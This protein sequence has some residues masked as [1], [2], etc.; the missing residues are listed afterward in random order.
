MTYKVPVGVSGSAPAAQLKRYAATGPRHISISVLLLLG[1]LIA[2][3]TSVAENNEMSPKPERKVADRPPIMEDVYVLIAEMQVTHRTERWAHEDKT[4]LEFEEFIE[5]AEA[6]R[7]PGLGV[8]LPK[9]EEC[10]EANG[11]KK[12]RTAYWPHNNTLEQPGDA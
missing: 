9:I 10:M 3:C 5:C 6:T 7:P 4:R 12:E 8:S 1:L 2:G 11:W